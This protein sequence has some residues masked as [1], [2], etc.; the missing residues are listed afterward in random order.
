MPIEREN[1]LER[2][3]NKCYTN[4]EI[5]EMKTI[6]QKNHNVKTYFKIQK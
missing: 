6:T 5:Q 2:K 4:K 1:L 3:I